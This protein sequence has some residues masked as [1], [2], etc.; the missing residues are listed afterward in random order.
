[1]F[2]NV[3]VRHSTEFKGQTLSLETGLL[4]P[5][6]TSAVLGKAGETT[7][8]VNVVVGRPKEVDY[9]P[10]QVIYEE[11]YYASGKFRN[12]LFMKREGKPTDNAVLIG[13]MIDRSLRS[14]FKDSIRNDIQIIVN[15]LSI[16]E[17]NKPDLLAVMAASSA[18]MLAGISP[19]W[20]KFDAGAKEEGKNVK[21][22]TVIFDLSTQK[23]AL[24]TDSQKQN[25]SPNNILGNYSCSRYVQ[26]GEKTVLPSVIVLQ[27]MEGQEVADLE[28]MSSDEI[29]K[30]LASKPDV[31]EN[32][33]QFAFRRSASLAIKNGLDFSSFANVYEASL[34]FE[35]QTPLFKGPVSSVRVGLVKKDYGKILLDNYSPVLEKISN[36]QELSPLMPQL[37]KAA[38]S[39]DWSDPADKKALEEVTRLLGKVSP[40]S[41]I[42]F[43]TNLMQGQ[44]TPKQDHTDWEE[45]YDYVINP[46]YKES[47]NSRMDLVVSGTDGSICMVECGA[48][49]VP[50]EIIAK[51]LDLVTSEIA[52][53]NRFQNEFVAKVKNS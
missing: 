14:L 24:L 47:E 28:F 48:D 41:A 50:E 12:S 34:E 37:I 51:G 39:L 2:N 33:S 40:Q 19:D 52:V 23:Y 13:R 10:V 5:Q 38:S 45:K 3:P 27:N 9:L 22:F 21:D 8:L 6:A 49:I 42:Q 17:I 18:L 7:V 1:M 29:I 36:P 53:L 11:R 43:K 25:F 15:L 26:I 30:S 16:D 32:A 4:S 35:P 46:T 20:G 31:G 44:M